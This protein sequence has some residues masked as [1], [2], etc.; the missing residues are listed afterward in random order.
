MHPC[1][2]TILLFGTHDAVNAMPFD[3]DG[4]LIVGIFSPG[5]TKYFVAWADIHKDEL[6][7]L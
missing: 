7:A 1:V 5:H 6:T 3:L 2:L 4:N